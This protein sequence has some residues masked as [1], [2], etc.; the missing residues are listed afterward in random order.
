MPARSVH[1]QVENL[2]LPSL[3]QAGQQGQESLRIAP[4]R[5]H[6]AVPTLQGGHPPKD[7]SGVDGCW[8]WGRGKVDPVAPI[9]G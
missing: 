5:A 2:S 6:Q 8:P 7:I 4:G 1:E 3:P 9:P